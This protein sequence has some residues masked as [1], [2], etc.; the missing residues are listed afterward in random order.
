MHFLFCLWQQSPAGSLSWV[1]IVLQWLKDQVFLKLLRNLPASVCGQLAHKSRRFT[2]TALVR[3]C[4][5]FNIKP[6]FSRER[7][8][9]AWCAPETLRFKEW[10]VL[11]NISL[12]INQSHVQTQSYMSQSASDCFLT[13][14]L[15]PQELQRNTPTF[16]TLWEFCLPSSLR[17][18][19]FSFISVFP[20]QRQV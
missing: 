10:L 6:R 1:L 20:L 18:R 14:S 16:W 11:F 5:Q 4:I 2:L 19:S 17:V 13:S 12:I 8:D 7:P 15:H 9:E 3:R